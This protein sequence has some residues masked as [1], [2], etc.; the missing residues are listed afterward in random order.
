MLRTLERRENHFT[1]KQ[2]NLNSILGY[3]LCRLF[4]IPFTFPPYDKWEVTALSCHGLQQWA[5]M[6][7][8]NV[9]RR[10][11]HIA[12]CSYSYGSRYLLYSN[13][14]GSQNSMLQGYSIWARWANVSIIFGIT[15]GVFLACTASP[16]TPS[17]H[18]GSRMAPERRPVEWTWWKLVNSH[19]S[20]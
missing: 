14:L 10:A 1:E 7:S 5:T 6:I 18:T 3:S 2:L 16:T 4:Q 15:T 9:Q 8:Y 13:N 19:L 12:C 17:Y 20:T 11:I